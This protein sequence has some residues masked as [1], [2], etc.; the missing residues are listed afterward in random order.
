MG[1]DE[2]EF[3]PGYHQNLITFQ[4]V[5]L[6]QTFFVSNY[7]FP[8]GQITFFFK[9]NRKSIFSPSNEHNS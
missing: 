5:W 8:P 7:P 3:H 6:F 9:Y 1:I 2:I 4:E